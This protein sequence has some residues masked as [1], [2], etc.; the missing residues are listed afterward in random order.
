MNLNDDEDS[1]EMVLMYEIGVEKLKVPIKEEY[2]L[3]PT[4][5]V[6]C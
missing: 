3:T 2:I 5:S 6:S 1:S 4:F